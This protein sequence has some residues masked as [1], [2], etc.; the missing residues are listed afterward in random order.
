MSEKRHYFDRLSMALEDCYKCKEYC[1]QMLKTS[2]S[3]GLYEDRIV[4]EALFVALVVTYGRLFTKSKLL[5]AEDKVKYAVRVKYDTLINDFIEGLELPL[6]NV[7]KNLI[8][9][10]HVAIAHSD[11]LSRDYKHEDMSMTVSGKNPYYPW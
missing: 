4:R 7:H 11:A 10:R 6:K 5:A 9:K 8:G 1:E 3:D 2:E